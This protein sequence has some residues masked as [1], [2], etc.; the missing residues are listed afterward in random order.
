MKTTFSLLFTLSLGFLSVA[1]NPL[2][3]FDHLVNKTWRTDTQWENKNAFFQEITFEYALNSSLVLTKTKGHIN[4]EQTQIGERN[5]GIRQYDQSKKTIYFV[6]YDIFGGKTEGSVIAQN[7]N[8]IYTYT[9]GGVELTEKWIY[10]NPKTYTYKIGIWKDD[11]WETL[12]LE[13][14]FNQV[15]NK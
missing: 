6:E 12:Y 1:Q 5:F 15:I 2:D 7:K 4:K 10:V 13:S 9:Y 8:L 14:Q 11:T 3:V